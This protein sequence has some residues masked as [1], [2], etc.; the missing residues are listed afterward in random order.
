MPLFGALGHSLEDVRVLVGRREG[1]GPLWEALGR[2]F[3]GLGQ[4]FWIVFV[5][6]SL[7]RFNDAIRRLNS[8]I[9]FDASETAY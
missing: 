2:L 6:D 1:L 3:D 9:R 8:L 5:F 7:I 4:S